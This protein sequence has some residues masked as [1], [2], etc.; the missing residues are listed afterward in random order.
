MTPKPTAGPTNEKARIAEPGTSAP[1]A[2]TGPVVVVADEGVVSVDV[3]VDCLALL[4]WLVQDAQIVNATTT[5]ITCLRMGPQGTPRSPRSRRGV[6]TG[7]GQPHGG[8]AVPAF[9]AL[10]RA[11]VAIVRGADTE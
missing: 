5:A 6:R 10:G 11:I 3:V 4:E 7:A 8:A 1:G 2:T 9:G